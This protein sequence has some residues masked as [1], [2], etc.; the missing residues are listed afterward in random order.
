[1]HAGLE[2]STNKQSEYLTKL[3]FKKQE[4]ERTSNLSL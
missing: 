3:L 2:N 1:L 4:G